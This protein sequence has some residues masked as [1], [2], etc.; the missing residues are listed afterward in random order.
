MTTIQELPKEKTTEITEKQEIETTDKEAPDHNTILAT[1]E[2]DSI[3]P[4]DEI[5]I[6]AKTGISQTLAIQESADKKGK[7][8]RQDAPG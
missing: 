2:T 7:D 4:L 6:N 3:Y 1:L 8:S 5:W